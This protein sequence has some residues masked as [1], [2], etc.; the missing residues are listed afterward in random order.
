M[1]MKYFCFHLI[2]MHRIYQSYIYNL[3]VVHLLWMPLWA[4]NTAGAC[5]RR[6]H[7]SDQVVLLAEIKE[8]IISRLV[9]VVS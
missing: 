6:K 5:P 1:D 8:M 2:E 3:S 4:G 7:R 9:A